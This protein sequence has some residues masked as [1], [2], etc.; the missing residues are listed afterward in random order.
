MLA[1]ILLI[2]WVIFQVVAQ[3]SLF[4]WFG[5]RIDNLTDENAAGSA[6]LSRDALNSTARSRRSPT[7]RI[8][9]CSSAGSSTTKSWPIV[10]RCITR[11]SMSS[12]PA[13]T[14]VTP[15]RSPRA[16]RR[17]PAPRGDRL[18]GGLDGDHGAVTVRRR[19]DGLA[20]V[21]RRL[22][23]VVEH[24]AV[25]RAA[26]VGH[27]VE[28]ERAP[29]TPVEIVGDE[30]P[31]ALDVHHPVRLDAALGDRTRAVDVAK[32]Y[33]FGSP[34]G[35]RHG[36]QHLVVDGVAVARQPQ[37]GGGEGVG[38]GA[39]GRRE[40]LA[41]LGERAGGGLGDAGDRVAG[42]GA[43]AHRERDGL[44]AVEDE[45]RDGDAAGAELIAAGGA[46]S[47]FDRIAE[48]AEVVDVA[49]DRALGDTQPLGERGTGELASRPAA[50]TAVRAGAR[51]WP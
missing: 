37:G 41:Q 1:M 7:S 32:V 6:F 26:H 49:P 31:A 2:G 12:A 36:Q 48:A 11:Y 3:Q 20:D 27:A 46:A 35:G 40:R 39:G 34:A 47:G 45:G 42:G 22:G 43:H 13:V 33:T 8:A 17:S 51:W 4:D 25:S 28:A 9:A 23:R 30:V 50:R 29:R 44:L 10:P 15:R 38:L 19:G 21:L 24:D 16:P 18:D 14:R 5:D